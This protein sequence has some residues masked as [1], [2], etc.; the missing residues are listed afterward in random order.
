[1]CLCCYLH[2]VVGFDQFLEHKH[3]AAVRQLTLQEVAIETTRTENT[4][5]D[6]IFE[7][8]AVLK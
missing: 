4:D 6:L 3:P 8:N 5:F 1:M 7:Q 2:I